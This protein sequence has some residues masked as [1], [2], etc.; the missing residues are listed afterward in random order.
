MREMANQ[1]KQLF[2][3]CYIQYIFARE[4]TVA[5]GVDRSTDV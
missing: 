2:Y 5:Y 1:I 4:I 3:F